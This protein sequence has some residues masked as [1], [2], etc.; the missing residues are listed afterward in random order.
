MNFPI[1]TV[2]PDRRGF[3][4]FCITCLRDSVKSSRV[5]TIPS[6]SAAWS[7]STESLQPHERSTRLMSSARAASGDCS[8]DSKKSSALDCNGEAGFMIASV[9]SLMSRATSR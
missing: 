3:Q 6:K 7:A 9:V 4:S 2:S 5:L 8:R 1:D